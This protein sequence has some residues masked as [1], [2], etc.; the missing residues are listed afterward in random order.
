MLRAFVVVPVMLTGSDWTEWSL[1]DWGQ[2]SS[3]VSQSI[4]QM[5]TLAGPSPSISNFFFSSFCKVAVCD[6]WQL[7][8]L[9][10]LFASKLHQLTSHDIS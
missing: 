10:C 4:L 1:T 8:G 5:C 3:R 7:D 6:L 2:G 9:L